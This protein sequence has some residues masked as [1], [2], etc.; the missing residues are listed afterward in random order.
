VRLTVRSRGTAGGPSTWLHAWEPDERPHAAGVLVHGLGEHGGRYAHV[1][2]RFARAS[3]ALYAFD[4]PGHG[5]SSG[6][7][8]HARFDAILDEI[9]HRLAEAGAAAPGVPLFLY[10]H[11]LGALAVLA[12]LGRRRA[13]VSAAVVSASPLRNALQRQRVKVAVTRVLGHLVPWVTLPSGLDCEHLSRDPAVVEAYRR[14]PLV[15]D[16]MSLGLALDAIKAVDE[17]DRGAAPLVPLLV[18]HGTGDAIAWV[19]GSRELCRR[20]G[21]G[22][23]LREHEG[24]RHEPHNEPERDAVLD[25]VISWLARQVREAA[26]SGSTR[27]GG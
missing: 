25:D 17:L 18:L 21:A 8:G 1:G 15:H 13:P 2:A 11:S 3:F 24:L 5:L 20:V 4:L 22:A 26:P 23:S 6:R 27:H 16:R 7:R 10:G 12:H 14:D 9:D 19:E